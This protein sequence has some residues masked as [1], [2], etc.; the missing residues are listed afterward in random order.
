MHGQVTIFG[1]QP[2]RP[3]I[4]HAIEMGHSYSAPKTRARG[5][6]SP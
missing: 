4:A 3:P 5:D 6:G 2:E 1:Y